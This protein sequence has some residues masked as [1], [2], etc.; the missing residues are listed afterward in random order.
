MVIGQTRLCFN[1]G[2]AMPAL[3]SAGSSEKSRPS[4]DTAGDTLQQASRLDASRLRGPGGPTY[5]IIFLH[6]LQT[7][8]GAANDVR[9]IPKAACLS[10][11]QDS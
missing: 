11:A 6:E 4:A 7:A 3:P 1:R 8:L 10:L 2:T 9:C 5:V